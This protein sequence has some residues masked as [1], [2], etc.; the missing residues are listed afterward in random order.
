MTTDVDDNETRAYRAGFEAFTKAFLKVL[1]DDA[2]HT[3]KTRTHVHTTMVAMPDRGIGVTIKYVI[4]IGDV[5]QLSDVEE[6]MAAAAQTP[7]KVA[8]G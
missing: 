5:V 1:G 8:V 6:L 4:D 7:G 3:L 2:F